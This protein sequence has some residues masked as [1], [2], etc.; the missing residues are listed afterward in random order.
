M[1]YQVFDKI[2]LIPKGNDDIKLFYFNFTRQWSLSIFALNKNH[3]ASFINISRKNNKCAK[4]KLVQNVYRWMLKVIK[5]LQ[6]E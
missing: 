4:I 3:F 6:N 5:I 1:N 2:I